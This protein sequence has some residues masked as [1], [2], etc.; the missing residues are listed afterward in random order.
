MGNW[1]LA[2][3]SRQ[4]TH[5][6]IISRAEFFGETSNHPGDSPLLQPR[7]GILRL[8]AFPKL[9]SP[10]FF[11]SDFIIYLFLER[12]EGREG[13]RG[14]ETSMCGCLSCTPYWG[15]GPQPR[16]VPWLGIKPATLWF[17]A[18]AQ[19]TELHQPGHKITFQKEEISDLSWN[20]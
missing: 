19:S 2:A 15:P 13:E 12:E 5:S 11:L 4:H 18:R 7:F 17:A 16:H 14:R 6:W 10:F 1:W 9:K 20:S 3:S 8:L